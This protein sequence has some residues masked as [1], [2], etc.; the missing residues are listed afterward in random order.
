MTSPVLGSALARLVSGHDLTQE[1]MAAAVSAVM[2]GEA[3][4]AQIGGFLVALRMKGET[5]AE[6]AGAATAMRSRARSI[7]VSGQGGPLLDTCGT[8][9]DG[10]GTFN[11]STAAA[12]VVA[13]AGF[14]VA[15]HGNRSVSSRC[16]SADVLERL[17]LNLDAPPELVERALAEVGVAFLFAPLLHAAMRHAAAPR[18]ELGLR[19]VFNLLGPL[20]NPAGATHQLVGV[21]EAR[22]TRPVAEVLG[23]LGCAGALVVCGE[24]GL[25]EISLSG[26]TR[27]SQLRGGKVSDYTIRPE[28]LGFRPVPLAAVRGGDVAENARLLLATL[29]GEDGPRTEMVILNAAGALVAAGLEWP[30]AT[31]AARRSVESGAALAKLEALIAACGQTE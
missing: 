11:V 19:T 4:P 9:G 23:R 7:R 25:D 27:V 29:R 13:G 3:S 26:P 20:T 31:G 17:G 14:Q 16:G 5:V 22:L 30:E 21:Y 24:G 10:A 15:K 28:E 6:I 2:D 18:R 1:E 8:G 12:F